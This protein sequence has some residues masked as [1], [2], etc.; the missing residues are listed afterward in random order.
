M[1]AGELQV[2]V[3]NVQLL[4]PRKVCDSDC[5]E[6]GARDFLSTRCSQ[7]TS[8]IESG[9]HNFESSARLLRCR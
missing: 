1:L 9:E 3:A 2:M 4:K 8:L 5:S 7:S 6:N